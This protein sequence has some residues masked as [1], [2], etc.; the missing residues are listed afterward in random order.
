MATHCD[1]HRQHY[2][3]DVPSSLSCCDKNHLFT[4]I[5]TDGYST[6]FL[7]KEHRFNWEIYFLTYTK[8]KSYAYDCA[9]VSRDL[10]KLDLKFQSKLLGLFYDSILY[11]VVYRDNFRMFHSILPH[12]HADLASMMFL[13]VIETPFL[14]YHHFLS[15]FNIKEVCNYLNAKY[16]FYDRI[17]NIDLARCLIPVSYNLCYS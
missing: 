10:L 7:A 11:I 3:E 4:K 9:T 14:S 5:L 15:M 1:Y 6:I 16:G 17:F 13:M 8:A 12:L 2:K